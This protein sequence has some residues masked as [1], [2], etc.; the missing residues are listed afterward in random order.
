MKRISMLMLAL[1]GAAAAGASPVLDLVQQRI[2]PLGRSLTWRIDASLGDPEAFRLE[3]SRDGSAVVVAGGEA[4]VLYGTN[5]VLAGP[6]DVVGMDGAPEFGVRGAVLMMLSPSWNYQSDLSPEI[7]PWFFDRPLMTRYLDMLA[8]ARLNTLVLW[9]GHLFPH[10]LDLPEYPDASQ[11]SPAEI[12]RNQEQ[13]RWLTQECEKRAITVLTHF[14][15]I[16]ISEHQA[17][18]LGREGKTGAR[19]EVPDPWV[20]AYYRTIIQRYLETFPNVGLY[21]C[22]GESLAQD[23]Q[24]PWFRDV[25]FK[26]VADSGK[27]PRLVLRDWTM[28]DDFRAALPTM[29]DNL[30]SELKHNDETITSPWPD[31][32]HQKWAHVLA[33][34]IVN[35]HD[36]ADAV[37]YRVGSP[38]LIGEIVQRWREAGIFTG[39]WFYPPQAWCWPGT[40]DTDA[41]GRDAGLNAWDRDPLWHE[42]EGRYL[43]H[44]ERDPAAEQAWVARRL[45][46][47]FGDA[48]A[49][50]LLTRWYDLTGPILPGLQNLTAVR[51][52]NFFPTSI[53]W[54]QAQVDDILS[55]RTDINDAPLDGPTG[56]TKQRYYSQPVDAFT[57][58]R[59][60]A[61]H[62]PIGPERRSLPIAQ[63][64]ALQ[65]AGQPLP[66]GVMRADWLIDEYLAMAQAARDLAAA[67][68]ARPVNDPA[69]LARF[70]SDSECLVLTVRF[71][72]LKVRA[73]LAKRMYELTG[74]AAYA[75]SLRTL[76][77][78]SVPAYTAMMTAAQRHYRAGS[79]MWDAK[80]WQRCLDDKVIPDRDAQLAWLA[81]HPAQSPESAAN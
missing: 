46:D 3:T 63:I 16:H 30:W 36:P 73:A 33:G 77:V 62:G 64:A 7:Y 4:G 17:Q 1:F 26:A 56:L 25:I 68:A 80:S 37:P 18:A 53:G 9:S 43:W 20:S 65:A 34:H 28:A 52:G 40:L 21:I 11:F 41:A 6:R 13:F 69:E 45:G 58:D 47:K 15:N 57:V 55:Y 75:A 59:Y 76:M 22:P 24:L 10:I 51:F 71:Y 61:Q 70:V 27:H 8:A 74:D 60:A 14:Y 48:A 5:A 67:A 19:F 66:K 32:R 49:G 38:R 35:L 79:S 78:D 54:V 44:A 42:L 72:Q 31:Q 39:A 23:Q 81:E 12:H 29:Y 50:A 2:A